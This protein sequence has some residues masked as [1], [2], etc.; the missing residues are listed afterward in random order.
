MRWR[1]NKLELSYAIGELLIVIV[2]VLI[3]LAVDGWNSNRLAHI[4]EAEMIDRLLSDLNEDLGRLENQVA[5]IDAKEASLLR[6]QAV[7]AVAGSVPDDR[8]QFLQDVIDGGNY[9]WT[10]VEAR[11]TTF[12]E[13]LGSGRFGLIRNA[14]LREFINEYYDFDTSVHERIDAR[15]TDFPHLSYLL[16]PRENEEGAEGVR[17]QADVASG[18]SDAEIDSLVDAVLASPLE[19]QLVGEINLARYIRNISRRVDA[20]CRELKEQLEGYRATIP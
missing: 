9:G 8:V 16:V 2:G 7:F 3:A 17:G 11:R 1:L 5:A 6:I 13:L 18:L 4:E 12:S 20:R 10:Q 15:E 14:R 19:G